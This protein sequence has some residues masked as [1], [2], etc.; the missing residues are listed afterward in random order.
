M[1]QSRQGVISGIVHRVLIILA[2]LAAFHPTFMTSARMQ[3][4]PVVTDS[5][6]I[7]A[8]QAD[9]RDEPAIAVSRTNPQIIVGTS[10]WIEGGA[11]G[12]GNARIAYYYSSDGGHTWGAGVL[13]LDTSQKT[14]SRAASATIASDLDGTFYLSVLMLDNSNFDSGI[15]IFKSSD[16]GRTFTAPLPVAVDI[17]SGTA[18]KLA[19]QPRL[20]VD[21]SPSSR[22]KNSVYAVWVSVEPNRTVVL[23]NHLRPGDGGFSAPKTISHNGDMRGPSITNGPNGELYAA[24]EGIGE[25]KRIYFNESLD[26]GET[27]LPPSAAPVTDAHIYDYVGSLSDPNPSLI[28][29]PVRRMNSYPVI[30]VDRSNGANRG[31]IYLAWAEARNGIDADVLVARMP[32]PNGD[33]PNMGHPLNVVRANNDGA[34]A[35]QFFPRLSIDPTNG[36]VEIA[37]YDRRNDPSGNNLDVYLARSTDGG[38]SFSENLRISSASFD[39][40]IQSSIVQAGSASLIGL[41]DYIALEALNGKAN[42][43]WADTRRGAQEIFYGNVV[44]ESSGSGGG[45][46]GNSTNDNC[47]TDRKSVV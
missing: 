25:P 32:P 15:Y 27:F 39:A 40:T 37:F 5:P 43:M 11:S 16:N 6:V 44:F 36:Q 17:G 30:D 14:W 9:P 20:T 7:S 29:R 24:W 42:L 41:G 38:E 1:V 3:S 47:A 22:F 34:G 4:A 31:M 46:G 23:T 18:P 35:D 21:T 8:S 45:S 2:L 28:I 13:P 26:G 33:H 10:K 12:S 19:K